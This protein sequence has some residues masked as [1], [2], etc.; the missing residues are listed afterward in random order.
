QSVRSMQEFTY[1][2]AHDLRAPLRAAHSFASLLLDSYALQ[3][4]EQG[5][6]F[7]QHITEA[8]SRMDQLIRD[9]LD[10][11]RVA[12]VEAPLS[13]VSTERLVRGI[14]QELRS[15]PAGAQARFEV[16]PSL[17]LVRG[18][19][20]LLGKALRN[21]MHNALKFVAP[22]VTPFVEIFAEERP[23]GWV[24]LCIRD[25]GV[26]IAPEFHEQIFRTF[27]RLSPEFAG[28][29]M[30]LA[31]VQK[32]VERLRGRLGVKS[33]PGHGSCFWIELPKA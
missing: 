19:A 33:E 25:N 26:G 27:Q 18:H 20:G 22:P 24:R 13:E 31:I 32:A 12:S 15:D 1:T 10:Y 4:G 5:R 8:A 7:A 2:I 3:L 30:G 21:L 23:E 9:L 29:G 28:T 11:G 17:P 14:I 16:S 6:E